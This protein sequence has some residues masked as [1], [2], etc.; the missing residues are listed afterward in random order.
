MKIRQFINKYKVAEAIGVHPNTLKAD[1]IRWEPEI[2]AL[3][4]DYKRK[5]QLLP[6]KIVSFLCDKYGL[7][8][9]DFNQ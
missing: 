7:H 5:S 4:P 1:L 6:P 3:Y 9:S 8:L 2:I